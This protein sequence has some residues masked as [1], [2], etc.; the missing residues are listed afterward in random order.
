MVENQGPELTES[1]HFEHAMELGR[2]Q[3]YADKS[4]E[5]TRQS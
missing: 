5:C 2:A 1:E 4:T 3:A